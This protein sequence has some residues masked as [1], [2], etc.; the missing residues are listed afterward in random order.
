MHELSIAQNIIE[1]VHQYVPENELENVEKVC[2]KIGEVAGIVT[3]SLRFGYSALISDTPLKNSSLEI[4]NIPF[5]I[6]CSKC[7]NECNSNSGITVCNIC[8]SSETK[9][10]SG[11]E[12][13]ITE[14]LL[15]ETEEVI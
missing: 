8:G 12:M 5:I 6:K 13:H 9:I 2:I 11:L 15:N 10:I 1:I 14:V 3:E 4:E 7:G